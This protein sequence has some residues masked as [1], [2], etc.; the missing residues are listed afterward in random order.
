[1][2]TQLDERP[3]LEVVEL[4]EDDTK[5]PIAH[6]YCILCNPGERKRPGAVALCGHVN[7]DS[8]VWR[9]WP[10]TGDQLCAV[11]EDLEKR[12]CPRCSR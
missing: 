6:C 12:P 2:S 8:G 5:P 4:P 1:M 7:K 11:C 10:G 3:D 9:T